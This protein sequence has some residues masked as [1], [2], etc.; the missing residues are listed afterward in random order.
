M[1]LFYGSGRLRTRNGGGKTVDARVV[2]C[3]EAGRDGL[4]LDGVV[5]GLQAIAPYRQGLVVA[6]EGMFAWYAQA[7]LTTPRSPSSSTGVM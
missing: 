3:Y 1:G 2:S 6:A 7:S 4:R 5:A